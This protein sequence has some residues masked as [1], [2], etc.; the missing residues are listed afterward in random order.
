MTLRGSPATMRMESMTPSS[1]FLVRSACICKI[2]S[3]DAPRTHPGGDAEREAVCPGHALQQLVRR[4][5]RRRAAVP[6]RGV[7]VGRPRG[8]RRRGHAHR[9][10]D[11]HRHRRALQGCRREHVQRRK[12]LRRAC[13]VFGQS[14]ELTTRAAHETVDDISHYGQWRATTCSQLRPD[15]LTLVDAPI[16]TIEVT[17]ADDGAG[18]VFGTAEPFENLLYV[19]AVL[20]LMCSPSYQCCSSCTGHVDSPS[21]LPLGCETVGSCA[22]RR[23]ARRTT[24]AAGGTGT[25]GTRRSRPSSAAAPRPER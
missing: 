24:S 4:H 14:A 3:V 7:R 17:A 6:V 22:A 16:T 5:E 25:A 18:D 20:H 23:P 19:P 8:R 1:T 9:H 10:R 13:V 21:W 11:R 15:Q 12:E 2:S